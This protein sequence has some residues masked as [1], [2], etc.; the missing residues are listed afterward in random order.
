[1][2]HSAHSLDHSA[3]EDH[4]LQETEVTEMGKVPVLRAD[5]QTDWIDTLQRV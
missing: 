4:V 2:M 3:N 5:T 1:M